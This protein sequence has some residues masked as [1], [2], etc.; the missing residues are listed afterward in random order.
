MVC[1]S[2]YAALIGRGL[3]RLFF[4]RGTAQL[5][6]LCSVCQHQFGLFLAQRAFLGNDALLHVVAGGQI[7]HGVHQKPFHD[8]SQ[9]AGAALALDGLFGDVRKRSRL[10]LELHAVQ[11]HQIAVLA[12]QRVFRL[13]EDADQLLFI[14]LIQ[15]DHDGQ[16]AHKFGNQAVL[17]QVL[18]AKLLERGVDIFFLLAL[19]LAAEAQ[20]LFADAVFN[21]G[22]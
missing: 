22:R 16:A 19:E 2:G 20:R 11:I 17:D 18:R 3:G 14:Q 1:F 6:G 8:G 13:G 21:D 7:E 12:H 9:A 15:R 10:K 5:F 4:G